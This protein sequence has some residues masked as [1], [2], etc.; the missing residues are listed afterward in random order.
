MTTT[1]ER[2]YL[3]IVDASS[4]SPTASPCSSARQAVTCRYRCGDACA[5]D[6]PNTSANETFEQVVA[7]VLSRRGLLQA[8]AVLGVVGAGTVAFAG[9]SA[10]APGT[11]RSGLARTSLGRGPM[12]LRFDP[13]A[14]N[15]ADVVVTPAGYDQS[16]VIRWGDPLFADSPTFNP[17][18]QTGAAQQKQFGYNNDYLGVIELP[19]RELL[20]V[21]NHE[22]TSDD[23]IHPGWDPENPTRQQTEV[24]WAAHGLT[25]V[26]VRPD[27]STG[28]LTPIVGHRLNRRFHTTSEFAITGPAAGHPLMRTSADPTGTRVLGTLNNC[29]G[30][31]TPWGTW[32]TAEENVNQ[33]FA[34]ADQVADPVAKGRLKRYGFNTAASQRKW[35]RFDD[36]FD[37]TK[38]PNEANRFGWIV[39]IDPT[40]PSSTP[41]KRTAMG[42]VK[43]ESANPSVAKDGRV[44]FYMGDDE[45]FDYLYKF[46]TTEKMKKGPTKAAA[47]H[48]ATLLDH[49]TLYV[50]KFTGNSP[51][52]EITG[53]GALP[54]DGRFDGSGE[55]I[56]LVSGNRSFV[57][58]MTAEEVLIFTR[59]AGDKVGATKMDRPE[60]V[61]ASPFTGKVYVALT[62]NS[63]RGAAGQAKADE[64][65]PRVSNKNG[66]ILEITE[67]GNDSAATT[68]A[69]NLLLVCGDPADPSTYFGGFDKS[70]VSPISCPDNV[71]F[72]PYGNLWISTDGNALGSNDGLF[73]VVVEGRDRG[74]TTQFLTVPR[75]AETCGPVVQKERVLVC[76]QHPGELDGTTFE[77]PGSSWPDGGTSVPRPA[78]VAVW[79]RDGRP[80]GS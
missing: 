69:W 46:V 2:R 38:E 28:A 4:T 58:G 32:L 27:R 6:A 45:R 10:A 48:N 12:G 59:E 70:Q 16:V 60:D 75:G 68:F 37:L 52:A 13:V 8:G 20:L 76:V 5:H 51:A 50:A 18:A 73:G 72:D 41:K 3:S 26:A 36:R 78:I 17:L 1:P 44:A 57:P 56:P 30:G 34:N 67:T 33:Y 31:L 71:A 21:V 7:Q 55:W 47:A 19:G 35:E 54:A 65:N 22:Y 23:M 24:S 14:P 77:S 79:R 29:S 15:R 64:V 61:E 11:A 66:H 53:T 74:R 40:D 9:P 80:I 43:H 62:N 39:E 42:R 63:N 49:G 25:V